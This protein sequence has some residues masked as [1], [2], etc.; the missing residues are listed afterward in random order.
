DRDAAAGADRRADAG[1]GVLGLPVT[2]FVR[3]REPLRGAHRGHR[4]HPRRVSLP[5]AGPGEG[6]EAQPILRYRTQEHTRD[7][8]GSNSWRQPMMALSVSGV[9][10]SY[11]ETAVLRGVSLSVEPGSLTAILGASGA[12]KTTLLRVIA[13]FEAADFGTIEL[14]GLV[15]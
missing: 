2:G 13:G 11:G 12:G 1:N 5:V 8:T 9:R 10:K 4:D 6:I 15:V 7:A 3:D 14:G